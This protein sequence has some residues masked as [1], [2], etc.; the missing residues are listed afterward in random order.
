[1]A[2][3][4]TL[5]FAAVEEEEMNRR[6]LAVASLAGV[7]SVLYVIPLYYA[8]GANVDTSWVLSKNN[9]PVGTRISHMKPTNMN[10]VQEFG[11]FLTESF[12]QQGRVDGRG[13]LE[14]GFTIYPKEQG[15]TLGYAVSYFHSEAEMR[16]AAQSRNVLTARPMSNGLFGGSSTGSGG[17]ATYAVFGRFNVLV[18]Q[19]CWLTAL[20]N[21]AEGIQLTTYCAKQRKALTE[22][23]LALRPPATPTRTSTTTPTAVSTPTSTP[24]LAP[25]AT[26]ARTPTSTYT[27]PHTGGGPA[28]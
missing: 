3:Q 18:D 26:T 24:T 21:E 1:L 12:E 13:W 20:H 28:P 6:K 8:D 23:L 17:D 11:E 16:H 2:H 27:L 10:M 7:A 22:K 19:Y 25:T 4:P 5:P 9:Y 14:V 15:L